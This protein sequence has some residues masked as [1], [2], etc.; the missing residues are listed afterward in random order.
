MAAYA[1]VGVQISE[2][3]LA[4]EANHVVKEYT[5]AFEANEERRVQRA[6]TA[7]AKRDGTVSELPKDAQEEFWETT[8]KEVTEQ[9]SAE[10]AASGLQGAEAEQV[11]RN[12][13][14]DSW[15]QAGSVDPSVAAVNASALNGSLL[16]K[17]GNP[18]P[19]AVRIVD[20]YRD[21]RDSNPFVA[22]SYFG[23]DE[24]AKARAEA[25]LKR[26]AGNSVEG[27]AAVEWS[28][29]NQGSTTVFNKSMSADEIVAAATKK[30]V[31]MAA[32]ADAGW[33]QG[34]FTGS[35]I[36]DELNTTGREADARMEA[37]VEIMAP[38]LEAEIARLSLNHD[39]PPEDIVDLATANLQKTT[40]FLG[41]S[42]VE[43][44]A[45]NGF[46]K[47]ALGE[48]RAGDFANEAGIHDK[49]MLEYLLDNP[50]GIP[51]LEGI[52]QFTDA[53]A[54][55]LK[56]GLLGL[57]QGIDAVAE[58]LFGLE[59]FDAQQPALGLIEAYGAL[60]KGTRPYQVDVLPDGRTMVSY[61]KTDGQRSEPV[62]I[63]LRKA[64][65]YWLSKKT[66]D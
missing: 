3:D 26:G 61:L 37:A 62:V 11:Q 23:K 21:L 2:M 51:S 54:G 43:Y 15:V 41:E 52:T 45:N 17:D 32:T 66:Y 42:V 16:A 60:F 27:I 1:E 55:F 8:R 31:S 65:D 6:L 24:G 39:L 63:D 28:K 18:N 56:R 46:L 58:G 9:G 4:G 35:A 48:K 20:T 44:P 38:R 57:G 19:D 36:V 10:I 59:V 12:F 34:I 22:D 5:A 64:G 40:A 53:E 50:D 7:K 30:A 14:I 33:I 25:I 29:A 47:Q 49:I 13:T